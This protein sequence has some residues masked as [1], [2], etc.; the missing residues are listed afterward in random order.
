VVPLSARERPS[1]AIPLA[2]LLQRMVATRG[3]APALEAQNAIAAWPRAAGPTLAAH[4][5]PLRVR[6]RV[7]EVAVDTGLWAAQLSFLRPD[8]LRRLAQ[9]GVRD[10]RDL[11]FRVGTP[12]GLQGPPGGA[13]GGAAN[14]PEDG[15]R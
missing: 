11:E 10:L 5:A 3:W 15:G 9:C 2:D 14:R 7:L 12:A 4:T 6:N 13:P 1:G 8:L